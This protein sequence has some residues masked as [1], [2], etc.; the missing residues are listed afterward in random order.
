MTT[1]DLLHRLVHHLDKHPGRLRTQ[2]KLKVARAWHSCVPW[3]GLI[4]CL[5]GSGSK[6]MFVQATIETYQPS[7]ANTPVM[8]MHVRHLRA[9]RWVPSLLNR[10]DC[11]YTWSHDAI[12]AN[13]HAPLTE[14]LLG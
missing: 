10:L 5:G 2:D 9:S 13:S 6:S 7:L 11:A 3:R 4:Y 14:L 8:P 12:T 1:L